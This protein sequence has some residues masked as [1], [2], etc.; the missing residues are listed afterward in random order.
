MKLARSGFANINPAIGD[1]DAAGRLDLARAPAALG[2]VPVSPKRQNRRPRKDG[3][4]VAQHSK[5]VSHLISER[6]SPNSGS[7]SAQISRR[8]AWVVARRP[9][10]R[11]GIHRATVFLRRGTRSRRLNMTA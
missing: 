7:C 2:D 4:Q 11:V 9:S 8:T 1:V 3:G 10:Q 6:K 5:P